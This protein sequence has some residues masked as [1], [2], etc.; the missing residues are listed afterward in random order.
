VVGR[1]E[2]EG[3]KVSLGSKRLH[4]NGKGK[5]LR[6]KRTDLDEIVQGLEEEDFVEDYV[7]RSNETATERR[8]QRVGEQS[9]TVWISRRRDT[10]LLE[11]P[12]EKRSQLDRCRERIFFPKPVSKQ[13]VLVARRNCID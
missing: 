4:E 8:E 9:E 12:L 5:Q 11:K 1:K 13:L 10:D 3:L 2:E 6:G 7:F